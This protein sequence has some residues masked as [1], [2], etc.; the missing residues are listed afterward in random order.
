MTTVETP[1][2]ASDGPMALS[3]RIRAILQV[4][5]P[6]PDDLSALIRETEQTLAQAQRDK[7]RAEVIF[8][9]PLMPSDAVQQARGQASEWTFVIQRLSAGLDHLKARLDAVEQA[10]ADEARAEEV[11]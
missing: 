3:E 4:H 1:V 8:L 10:E 6:P 7:E 9:D 11:E 2:N 5:V